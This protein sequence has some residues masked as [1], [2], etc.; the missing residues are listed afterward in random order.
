MLKKINEY[1]RV[2][3]RTLTKNIGSSYINPNIDL[4][5][6]VKIERVLICRPNHRLGNLLLITPF[7]QE[8]SSTFPECKIDLFVKGG[9]A[10]I[11]FKN[12]E[13][14]NDIIELPKK[15]FKSLI[16]YFSVWIKIKKKRYDIIINIEKGSSSGRIATQFAN[17]KYKFFGKADEDI[18]SLYR[19]YEHIA[20]YPIYDFRLFL[21][22]LGFKENNSPIPSL[23]LKLSPSEIIEGKKLLDNIII[24]NKKTICI[25]TYATADKCYSE[26]WWEE[27]Y[28]K[29]KAEFQIK[30]NIIEVLPVENISQIG[31]KAPTF[32]SKDIREI[33]SLITNTKFFIGAD[34]GIMHLSSSVATTTIGLFSRDNIN[35]YEPYNNN[36]LAINTNNTNID[37]CIKIINDI[38]I[39]S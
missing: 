19:D 3:T 5:E 33:G 22:K 36:S 1:R 15:P 31:F 9:L 29:L 13:N 4:S 12:Y 37:E 26:E 18:N 38:L 28:E 27:F 35:M 25:F 23:N 14:I 6:K 17:A 10:P 39:K 21:T 32:Y 11:I 24:N 34:S 16:K 7:I 30:Y 8:I 2:L 20:K